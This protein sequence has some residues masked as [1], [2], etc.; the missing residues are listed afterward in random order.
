[1]SV[2]GRHESVVIL[3]SVLRGRVEEGG[4]LGLVKTLQKVMGMMSVWAVEELI[5]I[6]SRVWVIVDIM[7]GMVVGLKT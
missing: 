5:G 2:S 3:A 6:V 7:A 1:M 4:Y